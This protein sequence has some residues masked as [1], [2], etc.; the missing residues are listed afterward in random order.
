MMGVNNLFIN[1]GFR[2]LSHFETEIIMAAPHPDCTVG[3]MSRISSGQ[4]DR[5]VSPRSTAPRVEVSAPP[6]PVPAED[7]TRV[8]VANRM[9]MIFYLAAALWLVIGSVIAL[10]A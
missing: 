9:R 1:S 10:I 3:A 6:E 4:A 7:D 8:P 5:R 2:Q